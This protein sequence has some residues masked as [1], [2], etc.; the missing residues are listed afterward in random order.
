[1]GSLLCVIL[2][3]TLKGLYYYNKIHHILGFGLELD[4][5]SLH[6]HIV[7]AHNKIKA[8]ALSQYDRR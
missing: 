3:G 4:T 6:D 2:N 7:L 5:N 1:M 8:I